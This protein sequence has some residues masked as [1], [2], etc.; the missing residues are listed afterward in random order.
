MLRQLLSL[1]RGSDP[2][3]EMYDRLIDMVVKSRRM[4][5][6]AWEEASA[7]RSR[8]EVREE[9]QRI[10]IEVNKS[11]RT[12]RRRLAEHLV[13]RSGADAPTCLALMSIVKDAERV[14]DY[15][16]NIY[17]VACLYTM[18]FDHGPY[19]TPLRDLRAEIEGIFSKCR[20]AFAEADSQ[21]ARDIIEE[22]K[23]IVRHCD[24][25]IVQLL[26]DQLPTQKAVA[27]ALLARYFKRVA[28]HLRN[29]ATSVTGP[30]HE[31]DHTPPSG[32]GARK[33]YGKGI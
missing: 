4:Y 17:E 29:I 27:Y 19:I 6:A 24:D 8:P 30:V 10:D 2:L 5:E 25:M 26:H 22:M 18:N 33:T 1:L 12:I 7:G 32:A 23:R 13:L 15:C 9:V 21:M 16:K 3:K 14:G 11:E 31:I 28:G 20:T